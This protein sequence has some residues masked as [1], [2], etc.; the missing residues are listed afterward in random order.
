MPTAPWWVLL[1]EA[2]EDWGIPPWDIAG[3]PDEKLLWLLR[4]KIFKNLIG[5]ARRKRNEELEEKS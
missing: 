1:L 4:Y 3:R 2:A 5:E